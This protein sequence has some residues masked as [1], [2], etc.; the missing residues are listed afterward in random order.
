MNRGDKLELNIVKYAFE[1]KGIAKVNRRLIMPSADDKLPGNGETN[2][3]V[4][5]PGTYPGDRVIAELT[6][7]RKLN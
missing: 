6:K 3:I 4:F 7:I 2:Y 5:V 1:G